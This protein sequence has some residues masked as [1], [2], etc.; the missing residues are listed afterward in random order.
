M[1]LTTYLDELLGLFIALVGVVVIVRSRAMKDFLVAF[2][3]QRPRQALD[4]N[5]VIQPLR[6]HLGTG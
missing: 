3:D 1:A 5:M 4:H 6:S 2:V